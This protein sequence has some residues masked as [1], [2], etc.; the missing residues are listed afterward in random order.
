MKIHN[1]LK[2][3]I[4]WIIFIIVIFLYLQDRKILLPLLNSLLNRQ[5][6]FSAKFW[7]FA[8]VM[9]A[10]FGQR[11][12]NW[13]NQPIIL[14]DFDSNSDRCYRN[15]VLNEDVI[16]DF[17]RFTNVTRQYFRLKV[18]NVGNDT[19]KKVRMTIDLYYEDGK[20]AERF[21]P[22][23]LRWFTQDKEIDIASGETTYINLLS[24]II[25]ISESHTR[26]YAKN[27]FVIRW[28][29]FDYTPRGIAWDRERR[30]FN[31]KLVVHGDN[32]KA[33][34]L[35]FRFIPEGEDIFKVGKLI[36]INHI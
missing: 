24:Q 23:C 30:V 36:K 14:V 21:E 4:L 25:K 19:A 5:I 12:N 28:E 35:W 10:L 17:G 32:V 15:A 9:V 33:R 20:E 6:L 29:I 34:S 8:A 18:S 26:T 31:I 7:T 1:Q 3:I 11:F 13:L 16:Q 27:L 22:T 2:K